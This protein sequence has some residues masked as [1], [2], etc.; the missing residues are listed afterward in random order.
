[1]KN[2]TITLDEATLRWARR[3][4]AEQSKS[5]SCLI[6]EILQERMH[7]AAQYELAMREYFDVKPRPLGKPDQRY[8]SRDE[9]HDRARLR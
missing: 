8:A 9:L 1:M 7:D 3:L 2:V 6:S 5:L 4:A